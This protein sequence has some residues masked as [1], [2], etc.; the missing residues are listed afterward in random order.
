MDLRTLK[1]SS[2]HLFD[3]RMKIK[4][5]KARGERRWLSK[6]K[7]SSFREAG[8]E[9]KFPVAVYMILDHRFCAMEHMEKKRM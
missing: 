1:L 9:I 5:M 8:I 4:D 6:G 3:N 2:L 7:T